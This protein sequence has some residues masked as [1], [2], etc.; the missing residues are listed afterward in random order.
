MTN[1]QEALNRVEEKFQV[2]LEIDGNPLIDSQLASILKLIEERGSLF[3]ACR[4]LGIP[5]SRAWEK[6]YKAERILGGKL[7]I[8][9]RGGAK[10][11][12][13]KLTDIAK[14][15]LVRYFEAER[16]LKSVITPTRVI[17][18]SFK[19]YDLLIAH[20]HDIILPLIIERL[21]DEYNIECACIGSGMAL[22]AL[23][24]EEVDVACAHLYDSKTGEYNKPYLE[25]YW[26]DNRVEIM[27]GYSRE[28]VFA[29]SPSIKVSSVEEIIEGLSKGELRL[30]N[31][32]IGSG[33]RVFLDSLLKKYNVHETE[34][35]RG[36]DNVVNTHLEVARQLATGKADVGLV[37]RHAAQTYGLNSIHV[38][39]E[40]YEYIAL[41]KSLE[42][43]VMKKLKELLESEWLKDLL[44]RTPGYRPLED[45]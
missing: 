15:L 34:K 27:G 11:G 26:L 23:S 7:V 8:A 14:K 18:E 20:S 30:V 28:L 17:S 41:K 35:I 43:S 10:R 4:S 16:K 31:R 3:V 9:Q 1:Q 44:R 45:K 12:G 29:F 22:A 32:N 21:G 33:T 5:Y 2:I 19:E 42:K 40:R 38:T 37:L 24:L 39:W 6:I 25:A 36:Y 13:M